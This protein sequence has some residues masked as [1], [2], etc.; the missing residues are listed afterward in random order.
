MRKGDEKK[1]AILTVAKELFYQKGY[2]LTSVNDILDRLGCSKGSFYHH[3]DTKYQ[4]L[5]TICRQQCE[6]I[7]AAVPPCDTPLA[8]LQALLRAA[9]P[10]IPEQE[11]FLCLILPASRQEDAPAL[12]HQ[13]ARALEETFAP[14]LIQALE[15]CHNAGNVYLRDAELMSRTVLEILSRLW[16]DVSDVV[17]KQQCEDV[18]VELLR[19]LNHAR[20]CIERLIDMPYGTLAL[21]D[22]AETVSLLS[23]VRERTGL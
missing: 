23:R 15:S 3:F 5:E 1:Q 17:L 11:D 2:E 6:S 10:L 12:L 20:F 22:A 8:R 16:L 9:M 13:T 14:A 4:V 21:L 7:L 19:L 18:T